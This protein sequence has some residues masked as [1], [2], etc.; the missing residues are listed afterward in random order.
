MEA[1][2][3]SAVAL[4]EVELIGQTQK[5]GQHTSTQDFQT[6]K[7]KTKTKAKQRKYEKRYFT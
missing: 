3:A 2:F 4:K 7:V 1:Q 6:P 5:L